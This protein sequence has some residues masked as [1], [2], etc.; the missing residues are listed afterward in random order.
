MGVQGLHTKDKK[1]RVEQQQCGDKHLHSIH[2]TFFHYIRTYIHLL[3]EKHVFQTI[4]IFFQMPLRQSVSS[5]IN[6]FFISLF[7][8]TTSASKMI[9]IPA[10]QCDSALS[11]LDEIESER[12]IRAANTLQ[13]NNNH[14]GEC[15]Y[16]TKTSFQHPKENRWSNILAYDHSLLPGSYLN[17]S[18]IPP[19]LSDQSESGKRKTR[20]IAS[21]APLQHTFS[22][23]YQ[24]VIQS[25][26]RLIINLTPFHE[27]GRTKSEEYWPLKQ[28][29]IFKTTAERGIESQMQYSI[30]QTD[31]SVNLD[32]KLQATLY[33]LEASDQTSN[34]ERN[35]PFQFFILHITSWVDFGNYPED[36]FDRLL[37]IINEQHAKISQRFPSDP[38]PIWVHCSAGVGRSGT[39]IAALMARELDK[40][41]L[42]LSDLTTSDQLVEASIE[43][44]SKLIDHERRCRPRMVQTVEQFEMVAVVV[45]KQ[46][47]TQLDLNF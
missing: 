15:S 34:A 39:V 19:F 45:A 30:R 27:H 1:E 5:R 40:N 38:S 13:T 24:K 41:D 16:S 11:K 32:E 31:K 23:F 20:F 28:D 10:Y 3:Q 9:T 4:I 29:Q 14:S 25:N 8:T 43:G 46:I 47:S 6:R 21:Q 17:A 7:K 36:V 2:N 12:L 33:S 42:H 35:S 18:L 44:A 37:N 22:K 26:A